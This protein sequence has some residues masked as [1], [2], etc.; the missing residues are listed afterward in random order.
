VLSSSRG[1]T[2]QRAP[3]LNESGRLF[4]LNTALASFLFTFEVS[5]DEPV[6]RYDFSQ[7][8]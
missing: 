4:C 3:R 6:A 7:L 8:D 1:R 2:D 5:K